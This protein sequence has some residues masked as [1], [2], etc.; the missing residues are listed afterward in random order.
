MRRLLLTLLLATPAAAQQISGGAPGPTTGSGSVYVL[1]TSPAFLGAATFN[2]TGT[3]DGL[4][5]LANANGLAIIGA[6]D[7]TGVTQIGTLFWHSS[8][9]NLSTGGANYQWTSSAYMPASSGG[10]SIGQPSN[11][12]SAV[13]AT[14]YFAGA[15]AGVSCSGSPT[16]SFSS[17]NGIV[18]H[19]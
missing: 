17:V 6:R 8:F 1:Q 11:L 9:A 15:T 14:A 3:S 10:S 16:S 12:W 19:C 7:A 13:Y 4:D 18:T 5:V 2:N